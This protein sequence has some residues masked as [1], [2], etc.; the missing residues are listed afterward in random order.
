MNITQTIPE[1]RLALDT[2]ASESPLEYIS[3]PMMFVIII[4]GILG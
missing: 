3:G 1:I 2:L 4:M